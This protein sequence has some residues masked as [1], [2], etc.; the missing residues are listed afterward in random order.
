MP[1]NKVTRENLDE[2]FTYHEATDAQVLRY[3]ALRAN[4]KAFALSILDNCPDCAD[5]SAALRQVR[6]AIMTANAAIALENV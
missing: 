2:V 3:R 6:A 5:R 1:V 4:A